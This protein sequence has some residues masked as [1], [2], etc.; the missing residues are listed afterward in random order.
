M[1]SRLKIVII[2][3]KEDKISYNFSLNH[4]FISLTDTELYIQFRKLEQIFNI[5]L[6]IRFAAMSTNYQCYI[7]LLIA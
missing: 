4:F 7:Y 2:N 6:T 1:G 5:S 3:F